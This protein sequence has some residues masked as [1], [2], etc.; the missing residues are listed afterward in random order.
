MEPVRLLRLIKAKEE[1]QTELRARAEKTTRE[2]KE[3]GKK[4]GYAESAV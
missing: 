1:L 3:I 4:C 2:L